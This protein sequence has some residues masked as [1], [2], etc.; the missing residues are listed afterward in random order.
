MLVTTAALVSG[1]VLAGPLPLDEAGAKQS[2]ELITSL[3]VAGRSV[4]AKHQTQINDAEKADKGFTP[5]YMTGKLREEFKQITGTDI[6]A[7]APPPV[8]DAVLAA[9]DASSKAV[10]DNQGRINEP[11]KAF[12]GFIPAVYGRVTGN[13]LKGRTG[14]AVKQTTFEPRNAY[15]KP[16]DF[17]RGILSRFQDG[18]IPKG[19]GYGERVGNSYRYLKPIY[20]QEACLKCHGDPKGEMDIAGKPKEGYKLDELRGAISVEVP[21]TQ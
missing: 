12:K 19:Q 15:N 16:D 5:E 21:I 9:L 4:V 2:A 3:F 7:I 13:I 20:I 8:K 18:S 1:A 6:D 11:G 10:Q 17:E 14:I